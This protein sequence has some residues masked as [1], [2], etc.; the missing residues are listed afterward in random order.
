MA[1]PSQRGS[2][3]GSY[4]LDQ[5]ELHEAI[6]DETISSAEDGQAIESGRTVCPAGGHEVHLPLARFPRAVELQSCPSGSTGIMH[7]HVT[8]PQLKEP[9]HS[10]PDIA[11]VLLGGVDAS[12]VVGTRRHELLV[13][14]DIRSDGTA[15]LKNVLGLAVET[16]EDVVNALK[17]GAITNPP[18]VRQRIRDQLPRLFEHHPAGFDELTRRIERV[19]GSDAIPAHG[20]L[21]TACAAAPM[22]ARKGLTAHAQR[23]RDRRRHL[24]RQEESGFFPPIQISSTGTTISVVDG[25]VSGLII[26]TVV[27]GLQQYT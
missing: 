27:N 21:H 12:V 22:P 26:G 9:E 4:L 19:A 7:A 2:D 3:L 15:V 20:T 23:A 17:R 14:P 25:V 8:A 18:L 16:P 13:S 10:L 1:I 6:L 11:N 24:A 5:W